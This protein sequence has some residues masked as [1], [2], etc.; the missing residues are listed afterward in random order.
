MTPVSGVPARAID[1]PTVPVTAAVVARPAPTATLSARLPLRLD[2]LANILPFSLYLSISK[3]LVWLRI[4]ADV[5]D[6]NGP[7]CRGPSFMAMRLA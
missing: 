3:V 2:W 5:H 1:A 4:T 7:P 6:N